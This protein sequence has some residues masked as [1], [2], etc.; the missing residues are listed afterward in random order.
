MTKIGIQETFHLG[1]GAS[2]TLETGKLAKQADG[3]V[4]VT[5]GNTMLLA[6]I[7]SRKEIN[8][9]V[10]FLP[11]TVDYKEKYAAAGRFPGGFFKREARPSE[12]EILISR[13][14]DRAL[15][16]MFPGDYRAETQ[17]LVSLISADRDISPDAYACLAA[18]AALQVSD[19]PVESPVSEV[20]V[21]QIDGK[22]VINPL[23]SEIENATLEL[24][25]AGSMENVN[26]VEGEMEEASEE[27]MMEA[28][29]AAHAAIKVQCQAQI[30]L[31]KK[32]ESEKGPIEIREYEEEVNDEELKKDLHE[33]AY[34][35]AY[36]I[37]REGIA[38]KK[39]R[40]EKFD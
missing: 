9:E 2:T 30:E 27:T 35:K 28:I 20:R 3:S 1:D 12:H 37:A 22:F 6:T 4:V 33:A 18:S 21:A 26:M 25:V 8:P 17:L 31:R 29:K 38:D 14:I 24:I 34:Q 5:H 15:R 36:D 39:L 19:I 40:A 23:R 16:P 32:V 13:L 10:N 11:L 7:V